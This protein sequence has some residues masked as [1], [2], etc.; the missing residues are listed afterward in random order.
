[1]PKTKPFRSLLEGLAPERQERITQLKKQ[2]EDE[3]ALYELREALQLTQAQVARRLRMSQAAISKLERRSDMFLSTLR[4]VLE[5]MGADLEILAVFP[6]GTVR[7]TGL[8]EFHKAARTATTH[9]A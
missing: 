1:M 5:G 8:R 9:P 4:K 2:F 7:L 6:A 3:M